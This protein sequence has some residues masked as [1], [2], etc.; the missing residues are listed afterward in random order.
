MGLAEREEPRS[1][2]TTGLRFPERGV[3]AHARG[4]DLCWG[5]PPLPTHGRSLVHVCPRMD[6]QAS[7]SATSIWALGQAAGSCLGV[8]VSVVYPS[9]GPQ[10]AAGMGEQYEEGEGTGV[11]PATIRAT[12]ICFHPALDPG[13][14]Q[15]HHWE[16]KRHSSEKQEVHASRSHSQLPSWFASVALTLAHGKP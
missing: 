2:G 13:G 3:V 7:F 9:T 8:Q 1:L 4:Q 6:E 12:C 15:S 11:G 10:G 5:C 16:A 14:F